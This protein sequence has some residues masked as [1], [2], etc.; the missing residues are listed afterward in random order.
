[1]LSDSRMQ[2]DSKSFEYHPRFSY[3]NLR[4]EKYRPVSGDGSAPLA[5]VIVEMVYVHPNS[6]SG[7]E[8]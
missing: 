5:I 4:Y 6:I 3:R 8:N 2:K 1:M 7:Q